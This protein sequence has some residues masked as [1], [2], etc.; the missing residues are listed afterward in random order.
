[1]G[2][3][4]VCPLVVMSEAGAGDL[5]FPL[6]PQSPASV[7]AAELIGRRCTGVGRSTLS[8]TLRLTSEVPW[9]LAGL[10]TGMSFALSEGHH[11]R[12]FMCSLE[13]GSL[14]PAASPPL[15]HRNPVK[16]ALLTV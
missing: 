13:K 8:E 4:L 16:T 5:L 1:M 6:Q 14:L 7:L 15:P 9:G 3:G 11:L 2:W 10:L 12:T